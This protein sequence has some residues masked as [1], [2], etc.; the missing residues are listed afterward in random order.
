[1]NS[2][3]MLALLRDNVAEAVASHWTDVNLLRR[4]N[5]CQMQVGMKVAMKA[6]NWLTKRATVTPVASIITLPSDCA[7]PLHLE[8]VTSGRPLG[9]IGGP[10]F[11]RL[12]RNPSGFGELTELNAYALKNS[13]EVNQADYTTQCYLWYQQRVPDL[14]TGTA[15][16]GGAGTLTLSTNEVSVASNEDDYYNDVYIEVFDG[17]GEGTKA[18]ITDYV[19]S[20]HACTVAGTFGADSVY[21]TLSVLPPETLFVVVL[22]A[23][24]AA[25]SKPGSRLDEKVFQYYV[26]QLSTEEKQLDSWL[27]DQVP[28]A[29]RVE[30][31]EWE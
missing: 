15:S 14:H 11:R 5:F 29:A 4:M 1:M 25:L 2:Y 30:M 31:T 22:K 21:G 10:S 17:T 8:E 3:N 7:K 13:I 6:S 28:M 12:T 19:G 9:W 24:V 27:A 23:T 26:S 16:A 18:Q 20:T